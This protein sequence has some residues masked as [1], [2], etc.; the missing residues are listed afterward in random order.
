MHLL[1]LPVELLEKILL[2]VPPTE[3]ISRVNVTCRML[4]QLLH[5]ES[6]WRRRYA[7]LV[8]AILPLDASWHHWYRGCVQF[9]FA[10]ALSSASGEGLMKTSILTGTSLL[11]VWPRLVAGVYLHP[12]C[13]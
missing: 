13:S 3:L 1:E 5:S 9:E 8:N 11:G 12:V 6:F 10:R 2:Y 7:A 4:K